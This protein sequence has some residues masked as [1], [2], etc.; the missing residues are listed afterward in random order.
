MGFRIKV[1]SAGVGP[2]RYSKVH[3][4]RRQAPQTGRRKLKP[5]FPH[6]ANPERILSLDST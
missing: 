5:Q 6:G 2:V 3:P 1:I 4:A